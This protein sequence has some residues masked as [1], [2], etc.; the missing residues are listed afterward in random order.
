MIWR[1]NVDNDAN[2]TPDE[3]NEFTNFL[4]PSQ[5]IDADWHCGDDVGHI[6]LRR[7]TRQ[8]RTE[9]TEGPASGSYRYKLPRR[10]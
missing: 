5:S 2:E 9:R 7:R 4:F 10:A 1:S 6:R 3:A 8:C